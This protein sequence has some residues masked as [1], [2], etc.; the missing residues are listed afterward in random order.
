METINGSF[1]KT[2]KKVTDLPQCVGQTVQVSGT[3]HK[4]REMGSF[5]F[6]LLRSNRDVIQCVWT[7]G[8]TTTPLQD[9]AEGC[10]V[11]LEGVV[12]ADER[13]ET[14]VE[15]HLR[16]ITVLTRPA[17]IFPVA[18]NKKVLDVS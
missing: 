16:T 15:L 1:T 11:V 2:T 18:L 7:E 4:I 5:A 13:V 14:G 6:V 17:E 10:T 3:I 12:K 8:E 9:L